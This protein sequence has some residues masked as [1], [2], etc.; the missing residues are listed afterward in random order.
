MRRTK[1]VPRRAPAPRPPPTTTAERVAAV[2]V[3]QIVPS[4]DGDSD[5]NSLPGAEVL[6][7]VLL[8]ASLL[9]LGAASL[10]GGWL[11]H[12][13]GFIAHVAGIRGPLAV[14]G[15]A[16]PLGIGLGYLVVLLDL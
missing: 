9:S 6:L 3:A 8:A 11:A 16:V 2:P 14:L 10:P 5:S 4:A 1:I 15:A 13:P 7:A 12:G